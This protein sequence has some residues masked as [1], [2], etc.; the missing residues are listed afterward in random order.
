MSTT[1]ETKKLRV[2]ERLAET[3]N[4]AIFD[5]VQKLLDHE[6]IGYTIPKKHYDLLEEDRKKYLSGEM[7]TFTW[8]EVKENAR[9]A[10]NEIQN[11]KVK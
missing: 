10:F 4:E 9:K 6:G 11:K 5:K 7:E 1:L 8:D 2:L 3:Y